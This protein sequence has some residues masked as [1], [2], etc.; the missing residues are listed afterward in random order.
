MMKRKWMVGIVL[1]A[2]L[3]VPAVARGHEGHVH[4]V[5]GT[6]A[7]VQGS[8]V[9][10]KARDGKVVLITLDAKTAITR[11][12]AKLDAKALVVGERVSVDYREVKK[13]NTA[14][15]IKLGAAPAAK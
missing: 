10:I 13:V 12:K 14:A 7:S 15:A 11:G 9:E 2:A 5:L 6:V 4:N 8:Q 1:A 3:L